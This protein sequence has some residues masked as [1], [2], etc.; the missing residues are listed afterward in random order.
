[1][2]AKQKTST[3]LEG[4][5][6]GRLPDDWFSGPASVTAD[7]EEILVVGTLAEQCCGAWTPALGQASAPLPLTDREREVRAG[8]KRSPRL[9]LRGAA[10]KPGE[11][12]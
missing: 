11:L 8:S 3:T 10:P 6:A 2:T 9:R 1:M 5:F 4:W 7:R 12:Q